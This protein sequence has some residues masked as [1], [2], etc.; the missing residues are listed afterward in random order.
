MQ[1][2][3]LKIQNLRCIKNIHLKNLNRVNFILGQNG[4]GKSCILESIYILCT[5]KSNRTF[6]DKEFINVNE[7]ICCAE[8]DLKREKRPDINISFVTD[9]NSKKVFFIDNAKKSKIGDA[10]GELNAVIFSVNDLEMIKGDPSKRRNFLNLEIGQTNPIYLQDYVYYKKTLQQR[11]DILKDIKENVRSSYDILDVL[12]IQLST[13]GSKLIMR[14]KDFINK[15]SI[16][17]NRIYNEIS[18]K[19]GEFSIKYLCNP[20]YDYDT[21]EDIKNS[22]FEILKNKREIDI[23]SGT[24]N[25]GPHRDDIDI[26]VKNLPVRNFG[27]GGEIRTCAYALK[28]SEIDIIHSITGEYPVVLLD[29]LMSELDYKRREKSLYIAKENSQIFVTTTHLDNVNYNENETSI[30]YLENGNLKE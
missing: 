13:Y 4:Q 29:D 25:S 24:T 17:A 7:D 14:R 11:N 8:I 2:E 9:R 19:E 22:F 1:I 26:R 18:E 21:I 12:D 5:S 30:Y 6:K 28:M 15:L 3:S 23:K 27:S 10:I 16:N 20:R